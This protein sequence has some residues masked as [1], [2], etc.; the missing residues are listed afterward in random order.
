MS[1]EVTTIWRT[2]GLDDT[3]N[4]IA[5]LRAE[6]ERT[7]GAIDRQ[8]ALLRNLT[9]DVY[10]HRR[11]IMLMRT[12]WRVNHAAMLEYNRALLRI[13]RVGRQ[14]LSMF[15]TY[16]L[17]QI[18]MERLTKD[19]TDA[20]KELA[21][22]TR[23]YNR[24]LEDFGAESSFTL[25]AQNRMEE[26]DDRL[27]DAKKRLSD[28]Q[29]QNIIGYAGMAMQ[30][31]GVY[32][33]LYLLQSH[34]VIGTALM[35]ANTG[36]TALNTAA[37]GAATTAN[38]GLAASFKAVALSLFMNPIFWLVT[39]ILALVLAVLYLTGALD[40]LIAKFKEVGASI[41]GA[42]REGEEFAETMGG[43]VTGEGG[44]YMGEG[45]FGIRRVMRTGGYFLHAG[46][47]V[48][49]ESERRAVVMPRAGAS[50]R[51]VRMTNYF[52]GPI[53]SDLDLERSGEYLFKGFMRKFEDKW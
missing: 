37:T 46:E 53:S 13:G 17:M 4:S 25:E 27:T 44:G 1:G 48:L 36:A 5:Q 31:I 51:S 45:Q 15:N 30:I 33:Q 3:I 16:M 43:A 40:P 28:A 7:G 21:E 34:L 49:M 22:A 24:Y 11:A 47:S 42:R 12:Q 18:R 35:R 23:I 38:M 20:K 9:K 8:G 10:Y 26:A 29:W 19:E 14:V 39:I 41:F 2:V 32:G 50:V 6:Y 52:S